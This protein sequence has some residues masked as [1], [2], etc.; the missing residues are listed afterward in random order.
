LLDL[1]PEELSHAEDLMYRAKFE[2]AIEIISNFEKK[3]SKIPE[4]Q[5][6]LFILRGKIYCYRDQYREAVKVGE[7]AYEL[8][9]KVENIPN[10]ID[11]LIIMAHIVCLGKLEQARGHISEAERLFKSISEESSKDF[12]RLRADLLLIKTVFYTFSKDLNKS[13]E[14]ALEWLKLREKTAEKLDISRIYWYLAGIYL[15]R[16]EPNTALNYAESSLTLQKELNNPIG[17]S[18]SFYLIGAIYYGK[19][20]FDQALKFCKQGLAID[21]ISVFTKIDTL[22]TLGVI[23]KEKGELDRALR[24]YNRAASLEEQ[25]N[26]IDRLTATI[27]GI[28]STYRMKG[29]HERATQY[30]KRSLTLSKNINSLYG[31]NSSL[32]YLTLLNLD[33]NNHEKAQKYLTNLEELGEKTESKVFKQAYLIAKAL[34]LKNSG[35]IRNRT[36]AEMLLKQI[37]EEE[38]TTPQLYLLAMVNLCDLFLE[39]LHITNNPEILEEINPLIIKIFEIAE[40]QHSYLWLAET[41]LIQAKLALIQMNIEEAK[42]LLTQAQQIAEMHG[43]DLLAIKISSEHDNLLEQMNVWDNLKRETPLCQNG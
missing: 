38:F 39:E 35:R 18:T 17:I 19:G 27:I 33:K 24:Y 20:D 25:E 34:V 3:K 7:L 15:F 43:L 32:F 22:H 26:E 30:L 13:L 10:S 12:E 2:E 4:E 8:S 37:A 9:S 5:L 14:S 21:E 41:K 31:M 16:S 29:N 36:E 23:Y 28:G 11:A 42:H 6:F 40:N 1:K